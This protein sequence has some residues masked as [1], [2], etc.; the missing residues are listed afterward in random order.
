[1]HNFLYPS[2]RTLDEEKTNTAAGFKGSKL[3]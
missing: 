3:E 1:M 2:M